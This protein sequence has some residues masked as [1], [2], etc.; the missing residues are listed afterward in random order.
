MKIYLG[1]VIILLAMCIFFGIAWQSEKEAREDRDRT[2]SALTSQKN[3][4]E[5]EIKK[6]NEN[7]IELQ[8]RNK[9]LEELAKKDDG[10]DWNADIADSVVILRLKEYLH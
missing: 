9:E 2:I 3:A 5:K 1:I 4:L 10:F 8:K 6:R 7:V